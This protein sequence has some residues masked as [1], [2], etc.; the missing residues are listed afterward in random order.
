MSSGKITMAIGRIGEVSILK[1]HGLIA[2]GKHELRL[3][4]CGLSMNWLKMVGK[5]PFYKLLKEQKKGRLKT[6]DITINI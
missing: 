4:L 6:K 5:L 3:Q 1:I 2:S